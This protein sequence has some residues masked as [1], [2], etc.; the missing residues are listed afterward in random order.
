MAKEK[1][2]KEPPKF[3]NY[4]HCENF[5]ITGVYIDLW[6]GKKCEIS[7]NTQKGI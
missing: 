3:L 2:K 6:P 1:A 7:R 5:K 4:V